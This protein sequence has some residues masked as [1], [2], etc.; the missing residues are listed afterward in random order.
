MCLQVG[1]SVVVDVVLFVEEEEE[2]PSFGLIGDCCGCVGTVVWV[3]ESSWFR[4][5]FSL[6]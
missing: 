1:R 2:G 6:E 5:S 4:L 3:F